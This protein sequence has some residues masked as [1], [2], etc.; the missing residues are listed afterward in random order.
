M[1]VMRIEVKKLTDLGPSRVAY[2]DL[3]EDFGLACL[4][5]DKGEVTLYLNDSRCRSW[6]KEEHPNI[7][8]V[9]WFC[10]DQVLLYPVTTSAAIVSARSWA[11][12]ELAWP[13]ELILSRDRI[14][15]YYTEEAFFRSAPGDLD[16]SIMCV[17]TRDGKLEFG[18]Y[19]LL[20]QDRGLIEIT[21]GY[22]SDEQVVF[23]GY[24]SN[25]LWIVDAAKRTYRKSPASFSLIGIHGLTGDAEKA[26]A[27]YDNR[28]LVKHYPDLPPFELAIFDL[29]SETSCKQDFAPVEAELTP[30]GFGMS[31]I[32]FQPSSTGKIIVSDGKQAALLEF[33]D[34]A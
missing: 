7:W 17:F 34:S 5:E 12:I 6:P 22:T 24:D 21:A 10:H 4:V 27:I 29:L 28:R 33:S 31:E 2:F 3:H 26:Y 19:D 9:K 25:C 11:E 32:K 13:Y 14:F 15:V 30:A 1:S 18:L 23:T 20:D 16:G 8:A